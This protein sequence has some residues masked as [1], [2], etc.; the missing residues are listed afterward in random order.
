M[1][2][3]N[4]V[5]IFPDFFSPLSISIP[6]KAAEAGGVRYRVVDLREF[7]HDKHRTVD[8]YPYGG[9]PQSP[10]PAATRLL[11]ASL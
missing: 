6:K 2:T 3:I 9:G 7:T 1:L 10:A 11:M 8:D 4:I 5:T